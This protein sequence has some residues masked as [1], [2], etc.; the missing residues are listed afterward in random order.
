MTLPSA[1]RKRVSFGPKLT[2][3]RFD[4]LLPANTPLKKGTTP[5]RKSEPLSQSPV[6]NFK[7]S[8]YSLAASAIQEEALIAP[9]P[10]K[11]H[12]QSPKLDKTSLTKKTPNKSPKVVSSKAS[13][14]TPKGKSPIR[15]PKS[16]A[17]TPKTQTPVKSPKLSSPK[18]PKGKSPKQP[19]SKSPKERTPAQ[20][21]SKEKSQPQ[22]PRK[23]KTPKSSAAK[24]DK[25]RAST[26][27][28]SLS[29]ISDLFAT[30]PKE[31]SLS[32]TPPSKKTPRSESRK[33]RKSKTPKSSGKKQKK[34]KSP[35]KSPKNRTSLTSLNISELFA[36]PDKQSLK[37]TPPSKKTPKSE[38][39][40]P[41]KSKTPK[42]SGKKEKKSRSLSKSPKNRGSLTSLNVSELFGTPDKQHSP[43]MDKTGK[44]EGKTQPSGRKSSPHTPAVVKRRFPSP[45][46]VPAKRAKVKSKMSTST[47]PA[48]IRKAVALRA[49][50]G[51]A[52][53]PK[54]PEAVKRSMLSPRRSVRKSLG[55]ALPSP[56]GPKTW[57]QIVKKGVASKGVAKAVKKAPAVKVVKKKSPSMSKKV[58]LLLYLMSCDLWPKVEF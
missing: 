33:P 9:S 1:K 29:G 25:L 14:K 5:R 16:S 6:K 35:A 32:K 17:K 37:E 27:R 7:K 54:L 41:R 19:L 56:M 3:E 51:K 22:K 40:K 34:S 31:K 36:T 20:S 46:S 48:D 2:P 21:P 44:P 55:E 38:S 30:P 39:R 43:E 28:V 11:T 50:H 45:K 53:T 42:S 26:N 49:I 18:T 12:V 58:G 8:R 24:G 52:A 13:P 4:K 15:S 57:A 47:P 23:S 10:E